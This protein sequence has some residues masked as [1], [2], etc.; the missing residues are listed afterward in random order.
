MIGRC[1]VYIAICALLGGCTVSPRPLT[2]SELQDRAV[3]TTLRATAGQE[4]VSK[5]VSLDE[6][7]ARALKY[8][9]S[10]RIETAETILKVRQ[11]ELANAA[12]LPNLVADLDYS[13]RNNWDGASS[14]SL[15]TGLQS[16]EP[17]TSVDRHLVR[18]DLRLS[19]NIL[20]FGL[21]YV[22][23]H[24]AADQALIAEER[25]RK[26]IHNLVQEVRATFW[27]AVAAE[28]LS[29]KLAG[30]AR[31]IDAA[32]RSEQAIERGGTSSPLVALTYQRELLEA[33]IELQRLNRELGAS[34]T[35]LAA[36]MNLP[37]GTNFAL[38]PGGGPPPLPQTLPPAREMMSLALLQRPEL[39]QAGYSSRINEREAEA[40]VLELLPGI[41]PFASV[42]Y[43][44]N[45]FAFEN[46]WLA[47]GAKASWNLMKIFSYRQKSAAIEAEGDALD[48]KALATAM[49][50]VMQVQVSRLNYSLSRKSYYLAKNL[51]D[52]ENRIFRQMSAAQAA[53]AIGEQSLLRQELR[54]AAAEAKKDIRYADYESAFGTLFVSIGGSLGIDC[55]DDTQ[56]VGQISATLAHNR[57]NMF[58]P[59]IVGSITN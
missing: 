27:K 42:D 30:F 21:S 55:V 56:T 44:S 18:S 41:G 1:F 19:W 48:N 20:D 10:A 5:P 25:R 38:S 14:R 32:Q 28:K 29:G 47:A 35:Q 23:A 59:P 9:L 26:A 46:N 16:L 50:I 51:Y 12:Q 43:D 13:G 24:Q 17:S 8:N 3:D 11:L 22:R 57:Y 49:A 31:R 2:E 45:T 4:P 54:L 6:A 34:K 36:L 53:G 7:M 39:R 40:A 37:P 52:V 15:L 33:Q 58:D